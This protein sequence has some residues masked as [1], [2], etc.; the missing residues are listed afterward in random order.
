M[1]ECSGLL[2]TPVTV[3]YD[4]RVIVFSG[5]LPGLRNQDDVNDRLSAPSARLAHCKP[6][7]MHHQTGAIDAVCDL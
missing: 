4:Q 3:C 6:D 5:F 7:V 2:K 1:L